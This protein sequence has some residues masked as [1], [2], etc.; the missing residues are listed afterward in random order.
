V[1]V[2]KMRAEVEAKRGEGEE[3]TVD[4]EGPGFCAH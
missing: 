3:C 4:F 2:R 1:R